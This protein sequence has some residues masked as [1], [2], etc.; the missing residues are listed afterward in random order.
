MPLVLQILEVCPWQDLPGWYG[1]MLFDGAH[2]VVAALCLF[3]TAA[4]GADPLRYGDVLRLGYES[5]TGLGKRCASLLPTPG[6]VV[7]IALFLR[8]SSMVS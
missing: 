6:S 4:A 3:E 5:K 1:T 7:R 8:N 2:L